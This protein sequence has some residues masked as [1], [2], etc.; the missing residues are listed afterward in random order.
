MCLRGRKKAEWLRV[1]DPSGGNETR[2]GQRSG[3]GL[4]YLRI[5]LAR[6]VQM[7]AGTELSP[8]SLLIFQACLNWTHCICQLRRGGSVWDAAPGGRSSRTSL[9]SGKSLNHSS[10]QFCHPSINQGPGL[11][12]HKRLFQLQF[13]L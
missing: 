2:R 9:S 12:D 11:G 1:Y 13:V 6:I 7:P 8:S 5:L 3:K 10:L 4:D